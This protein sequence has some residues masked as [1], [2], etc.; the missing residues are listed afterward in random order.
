[1]YT[2][3]VFIFIPVVRLL[4]GREEEKEV[5]DQGRGG[6]KGGGWGATKGKVG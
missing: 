6:N 5:G 3:V 2:V 4:Q 1:M